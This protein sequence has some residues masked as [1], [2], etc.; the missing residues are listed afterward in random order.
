M[1]LDGR[2]AVFWL[3]R[4]VLVLVWQNLLLRLRGRSEVTTYKLSRLGRIC[5]YNAFTNYVLAVVLV[6]SSRL[7][8][9]PGRR[10]VVVRV[11]ILLLKPW[12]LQAVH[13][14]GAG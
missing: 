13:D 1:A 7:D 4:V 8:A 3:A 14:I 9:F 2:E 5:K 6:L 12:H 10:W 11:V